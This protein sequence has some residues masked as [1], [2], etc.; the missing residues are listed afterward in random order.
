MAATTAGTAHDRPAGDGVGI[1]CPTMGCY[2]GD[3]PTRLAAWLEVSPD[4]VRR[5]AGKLVAAGIIR[6]RKAPPGEKGGKPKDV[7]DVIGGQE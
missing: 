3:R 2:A 6:T 7:Y 1:T 4:T 5:H